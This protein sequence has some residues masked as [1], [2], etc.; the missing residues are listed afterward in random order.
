[1]RTISSSSSD[2]ARAFATIFS[3]RFV[4]APRKPIGTASLFQTLPR[5]ASTSRS[6]MG[7]ADSSA[8]SRWRRS[9]VAPTTAVNPEPAFLDSAAKRMRVIS[10]SSNP[11]SR[12]AA[13]ISAARSRNSTRAA[14]RFRAFASMA[15][16]S[17][18]TFRAADSAASFRSQRSAV[19]STTAPHPSSG[20][21]GSASRRMRSIASL[22]NPAVNAAARIPCRLVSVALSRAITSS[23]SPDCAVAIRS[24]STP[25][26]RAAVT[27]ACSWSFSSRSTLSRCARRRAASA[28]RARASS[29]RS[30]GCPG[31][32]GPPRSMAL[33]VG[34]MCTPAGCSSRCCAVS[35][36]PMASARSMR[37][38]WL[39]AVTR[40][41]RR[42]AP[43][44][45]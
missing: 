20:R 45:R 39:S 8:S 7:A 36:S 44:L 9:A 30:V 28:A 24:S 10:L 2:A 23:G 11:T 19:A 25:A 33:A 40:S 35:W 22:S 41:G 3:A 13:T 31:R 29:P 34:P 37:S 15:S 4:V 16:T 18:P 42:P 5:T 27:A 14:S 26:S 1:M 6:S 43:T 38:R 12:A 32:P 21:S 17:R